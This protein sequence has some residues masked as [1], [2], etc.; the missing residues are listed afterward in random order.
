MNRIRQ[1]LMCLLIGKREVIAN[2]EVQEPVR[3]SGSHAIIRGCVF[4]GPQHGIYV[5]AN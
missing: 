3:V 5:E 4:R 2:V 1:W